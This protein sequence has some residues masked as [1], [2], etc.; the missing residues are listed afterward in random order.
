MPLEGVDEPVQL[1]ID[2]TLNAPGARRELLQHHITN[3]GNVGD[4]IGDL[5]PLDTEPASGKDRQDTDYIFG[6]G[7]KF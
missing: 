2:T 4:A 1:L 7:Y 6:L 3:M 5:T